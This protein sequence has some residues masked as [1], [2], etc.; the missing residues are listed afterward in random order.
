[1]TQA[2]MPDHNRQ[3][4]SDIDSRLAELD[5][6][7]NVLL[8]A[9]ETVRKLNPGSARSAAYPATDR[10]GPDVMA[11]CPLTT[12]EMAILR[13]RYAIIRAMA[14]R[15]TDG[16]IHVGQAAKWLHGAGIVGT[17]PQHLAKSLA[18]RLRNEP[19]TWVNEGQ[20]QF[21]LIDHPGVQDPELKENPEERHT[22]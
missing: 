6:E 22:G 10:A 9:R 4:I 21:R 20:G 8:A 7:R 15:T 2:D 13:D 19:E 1:M 5:A 14:E 16:R 18:R 3:T 11:G 12:G 17:T